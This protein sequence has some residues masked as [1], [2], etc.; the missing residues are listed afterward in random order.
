MMCVMKSQPVCPEQSEEEG[1]W[2][3]LKRQR[4]M[5]EERLLWL[6]VRIVALTLCEMGR[7]R[8]VQDAAVIWSDV[9]PEK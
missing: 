4:D 3:R 7:Y 5:D 2:R 6:I 9:G 1:S 8:R